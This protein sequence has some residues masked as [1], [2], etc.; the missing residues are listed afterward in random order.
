MQ[1]SSYSA[2]DTASA[3][4]NTVPCIFNGCGSSY[5]N[6]SLDEGGG[7]PL[8]QGLFAR[9]PITALRGRLEPQTDQPPPTPPQY[10][11][12][13]DY[14]SCGFCYSISYTTTVSTAFT[15]IQGCLLFVL[16]RV[17]GE[18]FLFQFPLFSFS[19]FFFIFMLIIFFFSVLPR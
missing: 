13:D 6:D 2:S 1:C 15:L 17:Q 5:S 16:T 18:N 11:L 4:I 10:R 3:T 8:Y 12:H 19:V 7:S 14:S 9:P